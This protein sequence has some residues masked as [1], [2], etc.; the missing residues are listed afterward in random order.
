MQRSTTILIAV[1]L[2]L[3]IA[4]AAAAVGKHR[5]GDPEKRAKHMVNYISDELNLDATQKQALSVF[6][7][8]LISSHTTVRSDM[9]DLHSNAKS[10]ITA[11]VFDRAQALDLISDKTAR[12]NA[13]APELVSSLGDFLDSLNADQ[14]AQVSEFIEKHNHRHKK[15]RH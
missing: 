10:L 2:T 11:D 12:I 6:K 15:H 1:I 13:V 8:Q 4:G 5:F 14:K 3:G 9:T 7:E